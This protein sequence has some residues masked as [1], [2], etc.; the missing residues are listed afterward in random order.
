MKA[1]RKRILPKWDSQ[2][3][4]NWIALIALIFSATGITIVSI[5]GI[6]PWN[7]IIGWLLEKRSLPNFIVIISTV[8]IIVLVIYSIVVSRKYQGI[9]EEI[10]K[11]GSTYYDVWGVLWEW[12]N[13]DR[14]RW[15][16]GPP[17][18]PQHKLPVNIEQNSE[19]EIFV[20]T[21]PGPERGH[22]HVIEGPK[23]SK[24]MIDDYSGERNLMKDVHFRIKA[25]IMEEE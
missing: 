19:L 7:D 18:C 3:T 23:I 6:V 12:P 8:V 5:F 16:D 1:K 21:C 25:R 14:R 10:S 4:A 11:R 22:S 20:F 13:L 15:I 2:S 17:I 24:V 9:Q